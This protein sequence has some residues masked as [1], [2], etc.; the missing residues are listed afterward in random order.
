MTKKILKRIKKAV[1][2]VRYRTTDRRHIIDISGMDGYERGWID[3]D[4]A[5]QLACFRLLCDFVERENPGVGFHTWQ[6][7]AWPTMTQKDVDLIQGQM[8]YDDEIRKLYV[9]WTKVRP[10]EHRRAAEML[11]NL[12]FPPTLIYLEMS[13]ERREK[14]EEWAEENRRLDEKDDEMFMRLVNVRHRMWT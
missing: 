5:M 11:D 9:W 1:W 12:K 3:A 4:H 7:Y 13:P 8:D 6:D 14:F 10:L 2:W